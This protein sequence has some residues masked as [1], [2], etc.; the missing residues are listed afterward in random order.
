ML[1]IVVLMV[2]VFDVMCGLL[3]GVV[4]VVMFVLSILMM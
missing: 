1:F 3:F 4:G 2:G